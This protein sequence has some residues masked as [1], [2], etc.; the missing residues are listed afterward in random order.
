MGR[1]PV[2]PWNTYSNVFFVVLLVYLAVR[3]RLSFAR[4]PLVVISLPILC[5]GIVGGTLYHATRSNNLWLRMDYMPIM[6]L[7]LLAALYFWKELFRGFVPALIA[8]L[9]LFLAIRAPWFI[10]ALPTAFKIG[11][12]YTG[13]ALVL[14]LPAFLLSRREQWFGLKHLLGAVTAFAI[15]ITCRFM[16]QGIGSELLPMGTHWLWHI[17]GALSVY[18]MFTYLILRY[19]R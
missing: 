8:V 19:E 17:F 7:C 15:A 4:Y 3:T 16:D 6:I 5:V 10:A 13:M 12:G 9:A 11:I 1:F 14:I 2:E 18:F